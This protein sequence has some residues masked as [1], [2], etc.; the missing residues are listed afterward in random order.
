MRV[1]TA[2]RFRAVCH[3]GPENG[4]VTTIFQTHANGDG[5]VV[6]EFRVRKDELPDLQH[7]LLR[8]IAEHGWPK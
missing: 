4:D 6:G 2:G 3:V 1:F 8:A 5:T 7:V